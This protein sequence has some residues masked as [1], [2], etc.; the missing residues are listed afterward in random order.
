MTPMPPNPR[1]AKILL[2]NL[3]EHFLQDGQ[4]DPAER[5][6]MEH[7]YKE[8]ALTVT[9]VTE[10]F[11]EYLDALKDDVLADGVVTDEERKRCRGAIAALKIP[12]ELVSPAMAKIV[13]E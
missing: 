7:F 2:R 13:G 11:S 12:P 1:E 8:A 6:V 4:I 10:V 9:D 5:S 3:L